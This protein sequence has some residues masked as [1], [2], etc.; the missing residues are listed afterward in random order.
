MNNDS[1]VNENIEQLIAQSSAETIE[2][3][4]WEH[5]EH[6]E[7]LNT[8]IYCGRTISLLVLVVIAILL[9]I[10]KIKKKKSNK[11]LLIFLGVF[12]IMTIV[13]FLIKVRPV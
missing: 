13:S 2:N 1:K 10:N 9:L 4:Y 8:L 12:I 3:E 6:T 5:I 7:N 11:I